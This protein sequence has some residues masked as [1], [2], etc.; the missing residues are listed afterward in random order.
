MSSTVFIILILFCGLIS[1][2]PRN[3]GFIPILMVV[4]FTTLGP[5]ID[6]GDVTFTFARIVILVGVIRTFVR[7]EYLYNTGTDIDK[8]FIIWIVC[9]VII[10]SY[11]TFEF[12][13]FIN[14]MGLAFDALGAYY[15]FR[16][17]ISDYRCILETFKWVAI[18]TIP[19]AICI[20][21]ERLTL[22]N[23]FYFFGGVPQDVV[24]RD[25]VPRCQGAFDHPILAGTAAATSVGYIIALWFNRE[26]NKPLITLSFISIVIVVIFSGSSGP[27]MSL[28]FV[29]VGIFAWK[30]RY[31][32]SFVRWCILFGLIFFQLAMKVP[33]WYILARINLTGSSDGWHR[34]ELITAAIN[35]ISEWWLVG[36]DYTRSWMPTGVTWSANHTDIT[37]QFIKEGVIGGMA[38]LICFVFIIIKAFSTIGTILKSSYLTFSEE[39]SIWVIGSILFSHIMTFFTVSYYDQTQ[40][41]FYL[42]IAIVSTLKNIF[43]RSKYLI[44]KN[45]IIDDSLNV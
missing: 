3:Y 9:A 12:S 22:H 36:T 1:F 37:N 15:L 40:L 11:R 23:C 29:F 43:L 39:F 7:R 8:M 41:L 44:I 5:V 35:H 30:M 24:F 14:S 21:I 31:R 45:N 34:A 19:F 32:M 42:L 13:G 20:F 25:S 33:F 27:I 38:T 2:L 6:I 26:R 10:Q 17:F 28:I 18:L 4:F 16:I